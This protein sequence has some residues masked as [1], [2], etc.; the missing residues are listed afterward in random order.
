MWHCHEI[1]LSRGHLPAAHPLLCHLVENLQSLV[2]TLDRP[3]PSI[4]SC[5]GTLHDLPLCSSDTVSDHHFL[6]RFVPCVLAEFNLAFAVRLH[7]DLH[8]HKIAVSALFCSRDLEDFLSHC[9]QLAIPVLSQM[10]QA[11]TRPSSILNTITSALMLSITVSDDRLSCGESFIHWQLCRNVDFASAKQH[12][13][14]SVQQ[15]FAPIL[16]RTASFLRNPRSHLH[17]D[18]C[19]MSSSSRV[20]NTSAC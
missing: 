20:Y 18:T 9:V 10:R 2:S 6:R 16:S 7:T 8:W 13:P 1:T 17:C 14:Q 3:G 19:T 4:S 5:S 15:T 12:V 11:S